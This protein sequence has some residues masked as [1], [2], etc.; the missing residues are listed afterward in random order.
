MLHRNAAQQRPGNLPSAPQAFQKP[1]WAQTQA[2]GYTTSQLRQSQPGATTAAE[3]SAGTMDTTHISLIHDGTPSPQPRNSTPHATMPTL[4][5]TAPTTTRR[6]Q[7][8]RKAQLERPH[9]PE[10]GNEQAGSNS[11]QLGGEST[12]HAVLA[13]CTLQ[14][15]KPS[16]KSKPN[17]HHMLTPTRELLFGAG[18]EQAKHVMDQ[19]PTTYKLKNSDVRKILQT[20]TL[21]KVLDLTKIGRV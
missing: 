14:P 1:L 19:T 21:Q 15:M 9:P 16:I 17:T 8:E 18:H 11:L 13:Q 2:N 7:H 6:A 10:E 20:Q 4:Q 12:P 5:R 3:G